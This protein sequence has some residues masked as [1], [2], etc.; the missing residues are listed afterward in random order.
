MINKW[1]M[2]G[3]ISE[4]VAEYNTLPRDLN[5]AKNTGLGR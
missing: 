3:N 4:I 1:V 5:M 2:A